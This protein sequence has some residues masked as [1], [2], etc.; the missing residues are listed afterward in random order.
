[1]SAA[2]LYLHVPFCARACPYCDFD[3]VVGRR[4]GLD[5]EI[6]RWFAGL[7]AELGARGE[8]AELDYDTLYLGGGT[9]SA[10]GAEGLGRCFAWLERS[11]GPDLRSGL[12]EFTVELNPEQVDAALVAALLAGGV[13][14]VSL[15]VQS[16]D[17]AGLAQLGRAHDRGEALAALAQLGGAGLRV[18]ADLIVG[19]PGQSRA[20]LEAEI[21][22]LVA[23]G[24]EHVSIYALTIEPDTPWLKLVRRGL[25]VLPD[26]DAQAELLVVAEAALE[27]AGL[28]H[29]EVAS[30]ARPGAEARHNSK[31]WRWQD[32]IG[33]GPSAAS[34]RHVLAG[35]RGAGQGEP[36]VERRINARGLA[37]W[38]GGEAP[39]RERLVGEAAAREGLWLGLRRLRGLE[40]EAF[41]ARFARSRRWL[42]ARVARQLE[43]G[44]LEWGEGGILR[45]ARGRWLFHD[46]IAR[47]LL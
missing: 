23:A 11:L 43:L 9:P 36:R 5:A 16:L 40:V 28:I 27:A 29:Y 8:L 10:L 18:S 15:G 24:V 47:D 22:E 37:A 38:A 44:N 32:V 14:R 3:F 42:D 39:E 2:G 17:P 21:A 4:P 12:R 25:R 45:V 20:G 30:Y 34:V 41:L 1:M 35:E 13:D 6:D 31:Y 7:D 46:T 19:W 26:D 33:L